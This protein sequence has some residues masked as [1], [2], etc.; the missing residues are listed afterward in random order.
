[1]GENSSMILDEIC[2]RDFQH[3]FEASKIGQNASM[4]FA[5]RFLRSF[6]QFLGG[7]NI[8]ENSSM[9]L[10]K[11]WERD[12]LGEQIMRSFH[13]WILKENFV[14]DLEQKLWD[15]QAWILKCTRT[16]HMMKSQ[17]VKP[18][19]LTP[20]FKLT[21]GKVRP[22][23]ACVALFYKVWKKEKEKQKKPPFYFV[24]SFPTICFLIFLY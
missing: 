10:M 8:G 4:I 16:S 11:F 7:T 19:E 24:L 18:V 3:S 22:P 1:M 5:K 13:V 21:W 23:G 20:S 12:F 2:M 15:F 6:R 9:I 17:F 14:R